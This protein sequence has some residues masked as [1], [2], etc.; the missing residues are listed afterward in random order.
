RSIHAEPDDHPPNNAV[1]QLFKS[2][3]MSPYVYSGSRD[4]EHHHTEGEQKL[5]MTTER[6]ACGAKRP[7]VIV[8]DTHHFPDRPPERG[9]LETGDAPND[10]CGSSHGDSRPW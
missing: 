5:E 1:A 6:C 2:H 7:K 10:G 3:R 8:A 4:P 9:E